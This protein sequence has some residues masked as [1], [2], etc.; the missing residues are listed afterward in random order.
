ME[1]HRENWTD[2]VVKMEIEFPFKDDDL[3][4]IVLVDSPGVGARGGVGTITE[5]YLDK[6]DA[7]MFL[8]AIGGASMESTSFCEFM[9]SVVARRE[10]NRRAMFL[11]LTR[12]GAISANKVKTNLKAAQELFFRYI[13]KDQIIAVDSLAEFFRQK[14]IMPR[15]EEEI[16]AFME[17]YEESDDCEP[18]ILM[19]WA[20]THNRENYLINLRHISNFDDVDIALNHFARNAHFFLL[21]QL[22]NE[23]VGIMDN[24][25]SGLKARKMRYEEKLQ[26]P[27]TLAVKLEK[28]RA[29]C[30]ATQQKIHVTA[31]KVERSYIAEPDGI[32]SKRADAAVKTFKGAVEAISPDAEDSVTQLEALTEQSL[33]QFESLQDEIRNEIIDECNRSLVESSKA[34]NIPYAAVKPDVSHQTL[35]KIKGLSRDDAYVDGDRRCFRKTEPKFSQRRYY[36]KVKDAVLAKIDEYRPVLI[37][38][39]QTFAGDIRNSYLD[40]LAHNLRLQEEECKRIQEDQRTEE[41]IRRTVKEIEMNIARVEKLR[42]R[43][44]PLKGGLNDYVGS[45]H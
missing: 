39:M 9:E 36:E 32:I 5:E 2:I 40:E 8:K 1:A 22:T 4:G 35:E 18:F 43:I 30:A 37:L 16:E 23:M 24:I 21:L 14:E 41:E 13:D 38:R 12:K 31:M 3:R 33:L 42:E 11:I 15:T 10:R 45:K 28:Q 19:P 26:E 27:G 34:E 7:V 20:K 44:K 17:K 6:A 25:I 29:E